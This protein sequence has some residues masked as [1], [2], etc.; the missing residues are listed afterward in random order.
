MRGLGQGPM[1]QARNPKAGPKKHCLSPNVSKGSVYQTVI[2]VE[3]TPKAMLP[4]PA[5]INRMFLL[6]ELCNTA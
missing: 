2:D 4:L 3:A 6:D 5:Q 1:S